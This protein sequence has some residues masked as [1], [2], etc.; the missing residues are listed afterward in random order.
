MIASQSRLNQNKLWLTIL[1]IACL[2]PLSVNG[3]GVNYLFALIPL[4]YL[5]SGKALMRPRAD[6][7]FYIYACVAVLLLASIYQVDWIEYFD[8]RVISFV[9]YLT[10]FALCFVPITESHIGAFK[11]SLLIAGLMFAGQS[12]LLFISMGADA[13]A[14]ESKDVVGSQ[15]Y[16]FVF[17]LAFWLLWY[18]NT[19]VESK[20]IRVL[21][22]LTLVM[23]IAL[24]FSRASIVAFVGSGAFAFIYSLIAVGLSPKKWL[25]NFAVGAFLGALGLL[26]IYFVAPIIFD[27]FSVRLIEYIFS[28]SSSDALFDPETS[29]GTRIFIWTHILEFVMHNPLTG[30]GFLGVWVL[31]LFD[32]FTG[33]SHSQYFDALFRLGP[34]LFIG[35]IYY[36]FKVWQHFKKTDT[37]IF[38]GFIGILIYGFFHETFK[39]SHGM[40]I[41]AM[42]IGISLRRRASTIKVE[43]S[44]D[45]TKYS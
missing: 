33:S 22:L 28:G 19:L 3:F 38:V 29:D 20:L 35:Y 8:R 30:S 45:D 5:L 41:L 9:L 34:F 10:M 23:G 17:I 12:L 18:D 13:Q 43:K 25:K 44:I 42:L 14:F 40:F 32:R 21:C 39:E 11:I 36:L 31:N 1:Y 27:F 7:S 4:G 24:T 37:G 15:R 26:A 2:V 16:G 6:V